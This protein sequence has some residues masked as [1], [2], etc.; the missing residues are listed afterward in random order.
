[1]RKKLNIEGVV[2]EL[3]GASAFFRARPVQDDEPV[4]VAPVEEPTR[5]LN[6]ADRSSAPAVEQ[7]S[8]AVR[9][10]G[11]P[12]GRRKTTRYA[13]EFYADQLDALKQFSLHEQLAGGIG[14]MSNMVREALDA[15]IVKR[16]QHEAN[17]TDTRAAV[18]TE[19]SPPQ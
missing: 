3:S 2:N 14:N 18:R 6:V 5:N 9:S 13:F 12:Y 19:E 11:R 16:R 7:M 4:A 15:Y 8:D 10:Y 17:R 1:M